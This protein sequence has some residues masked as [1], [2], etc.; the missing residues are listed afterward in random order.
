M[1]GKEEGRNQLG[2]GDEVDLLRVCYML[3]PLGAL[4]I[5]A[6]SFQQENGDSASLILTQVD[7]SIKGGRWTCPAEPKYKLNFGTR[8]FPSENVTNSYI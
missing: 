7:N 8:P 5:L 2:T 6:Q 4:H 1:W 3:G